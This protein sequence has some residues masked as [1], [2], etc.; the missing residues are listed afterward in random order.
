MRFFVASCVVWLVACGGHHDGG[1]DNT[2]GA[3]CVSDRNC[4]DRCYMGGDFP[5]GFCSISCTSDHDCPSDTYCMSAADGVCLF[6]CPA[7][8]CSRLGP[9]WVC[10]ERGRIG[11]G[12]INVC[13]GD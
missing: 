9:G 3:T 1:I 6:A 4:D 5:G 8:D 7:F 10:R 12:T 13:S 11:G 2:I